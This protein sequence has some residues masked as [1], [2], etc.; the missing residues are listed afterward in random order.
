MQN[1]ALGP[2][3]TD[4][5]IGDLSIYFPAFKNILI[6]RLLIPGSHD[7]GTSRLGSS[8]K[9]QSFT[10]KEQLENGIRYL[11]IRPKV[12]NST[13]YIHHEITGPDG[14]AD[15]GYYSANLNPDDASNNKYIFKQIRD[16]L[17]NNPSEILIL[18]FQNYK[19]FGKDDYFNLIS[20]IKAYFTFDTPTSKCQLARFD[21]GT[22]A[23]IAKE[24]VG[25]L[26]N[27]NK[28]VFIIWAEADVPVEPKSKQIWDFAFKFTP[29]LTPVA[30]YCLW[31][32]YWHDASDKLANDDTPADFAKWW[33][34]HETNLTTWADNSQSG[35]FV[36]QSQM[37]QLPIGDA[38]ASAKRNNPKNI[39][40]YIDWAKANKPLNILSFDFV[41]YGDL[42]AQVV[43]YYVDLLGKNSQP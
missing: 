23:Y 43:N 30:P 20:L 27:A 17:K 39:Q 22:G 16:F 1:T 10:I 6:N 3:R 8:A 37:Q 13:Y 15:L 33:N 9:T 26:L 4:N 32:P 31:D 19:S 7:S 11:D 35:F 42:C 24:T 5:W 12:H 25:S 29:S 34:W 38:D 18:K 40:H 21:H 28:R 2:L 36:L 41:N 14:S